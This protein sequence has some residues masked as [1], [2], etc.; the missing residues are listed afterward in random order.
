MCLAAYIQLK[1]LHSVNI[2]PAHA[3]AAVNEEDELAV[4]L[5]QV[6]AD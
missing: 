6:R 2:C 4:D 3:A 1:Y 5:P